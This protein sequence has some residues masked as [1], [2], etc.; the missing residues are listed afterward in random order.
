L[1][2]FARVAL[3]VLMPVSGF[4]GIS[5]EILYAKLLGN[6]LGDRFTIVASV[7]LT[8]LLGIGLGTLCAYRLA[9]WL[10]AIEV[11]I[12]LY[13][14]LMVLAY[15]PINQLLYAWVPALGISILACAAVS[16]VLLLGPAFLVGCSVP[17]FALYIGEVR[18]RHAFSMTYG[19]YNIGAALTALTM[20]FAIVRAIGLRKATLLL[21]SLNVV[22][23]VTL[24]AMRKAVDPAPSA[25]GVRRLFGRRVLVALVLASVASAV[26]QLLMIKIAECVLGP[27][28]ETF[29]LVLSIVLI[30]LALGSWAAMYLGLTFDGAILIAV[31]G[32][33]ALLALLPTWVALYAALYPLAIPHYLSLVAL[34][35][36]LVLVFMG[37]PAI[38]FGATIPALLTEYRNVAR[39]SGQLLFVSSMANVAGFVLM[40]FVLH[41]ILEYG[42]LLALVTVV[43]ASALL[44]HAGLRGLKAGL[45]VVLILAA[46][47]AHGAVWDEPM[48]YYGYK[49][50]QSTKILD[51]ARARRFSAEQFK[52]HHDLFAIIRRDGDPYF[53]IN[54]YISIALTAASEKIV[55]ALS[56]MCSPRTD[57]ALV[58][59][60]GSGA[61]AGTVGLLFDRTDAVEINRTVLENLDR[62]AQYNFRLVHQP[63]VNLIHDD[64]IRFIKTT[65]KRYSLI[66]N[67]VTSPLYFSSSKL[68]TTDFYEMVVD[69]LRPDGVYTT[70]IDRDI[71]DRGV[72]IIL[73]TLDSVFEECWMTYIKSSYY[74]MVCS[75]EELGLHQFEAVRNNEVLQDYLTVRHALPVD[76]VPY[77]IL[78]V[79]AFRFASQRTPSNTL[80]R[81]VLEHHMAR[82]DG[83]TRLFRLTERLVDRSNVP[84]VRREL[85]PWFAWEPGG[86]LLWSDARLSPTSLLRGAIDRISEKHFG[87]V[88]S[89][90]R[91]AALDAARQ[92]ATAEAYESFGRQLYRR[93]L[94]GPAMETLGQAL[95]LDATLHRAHY[96]L[97]RCHEKRGELALAA[98]EFEEAL[99]LRPGYDRAAEAL[100]RVRDHERAG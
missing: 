32:A 73:N 40:A 12:G 47:V 52:G 28:N 38:G 79:D 81:P 18:T 2:K 69:R 42:Q 19:L 86:F 10:W 23:G 35:F 61:T 27:F 99:R 45:A 48:L 59:G 94:L 77:S 9:R 75:N 30:G 92:T 13:A 11:G 67:T 70:W 66:L 4:C 89:S 33:G 91:S 80:D 96:Y 25:R 39:E 76:F 29:A 57:D 78:S 56:A 20:E 98:R 3:P 64:G 88:S 14:A 7:L 62:M 90:Y 24:L 63:T 31:V 50:F 82:L 49:E 43:T 84:E 41:R 15:G 95:S 83:G 34:K 74:L 37:A 71:G 46:L 51:R 85:A 44:L 97:G 36:G 1:S 8:F 6:L 22:V 21:A 53:F 87:D 54:G 93:E 16:V 55:G 60:V 68:Y 100:D 17:L 72:D 5:Y 26:F 65:D 58:L